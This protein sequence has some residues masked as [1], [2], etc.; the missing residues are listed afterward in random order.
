MNTI[1]ANATAPVD[2]ATRL[3]DYRPPAWRV[4]RVELVFDL[5][6]DAT[7]VD[8]KLALRRDRQCSEPLH[9][10]GE[11]LQLLELRLDGRVL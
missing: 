5:D 9:L 7:V 3:A 2:C 1:P 8:A 11:N 4:T 6:I 10:D